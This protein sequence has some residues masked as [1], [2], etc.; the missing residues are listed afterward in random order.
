MLEEI[1]NCP[2][3]NGKA[4]LMKSIRTYFV[5]YAV[6]CQKCGIRTKDRNKPEEALKDWNTRKQV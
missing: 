6:I 3:C 5:K 2:C 4:Q 1:K